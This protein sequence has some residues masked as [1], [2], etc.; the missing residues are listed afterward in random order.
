MKWSLL[1][2]PV[3]VYNMDADQLVFGDK[4]ELNLSISAYFMLHFMIC[5]KDLDE[6]FTVPCQSWKVRCFYGNSIKITSLNP[7]E[8]LFR[9]IIV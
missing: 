8:D 9:E 5:E 1:C 2:T 4:K 3:N 7:N 6:S